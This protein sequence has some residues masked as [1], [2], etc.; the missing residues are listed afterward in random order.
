MTK[1]EI[2]TLTDSING[3]IGDLKKSIDKKVSAEDL[4]AKFGE[5]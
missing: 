2:T 3:N 5:V 1:D 4:E